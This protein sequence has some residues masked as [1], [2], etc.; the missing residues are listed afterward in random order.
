MK[1][2][3]AAADPALIPDDLSIPQCLRRTAKHAAQGQGGKL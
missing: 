1:A 3:H 2:K